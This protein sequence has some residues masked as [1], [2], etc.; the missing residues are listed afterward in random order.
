MQ[1]QDVGIRKGVFTRRYQTTQ[2]Y[3]KHTEFTPE[4][5]REFIND[6]LLQNYLFIQDAYVLGMN[7]EPS[8]QRKIYDYKVNSLANSHPVKYD[9][10]PITRE[11]LQV[12][13]NKKSLKYNV[14]FILTDT[15]A[16]A[17]SVS[18]HILKGGKIDPPMQ[19]REMMFPRTIQSE[20]LVYGESMVPP[21]IMEKLITMK[22]G[23]IS[24]PIYNMGMWT[25][26]ELNRKSKNH[27]L[28]EF[29]AIVDDLA[30]EAQGIQNYY[31]QLELLSDL[32]EKYEIILDEELYPTL[33]S[34]YVS[35]DGRGFINRE[36]LHPSD[37]AKPIIKSNEQNIV[38]A[39]FISN[40]NQ[41]IQH[42]NPPYIDKKDIAHFADEIINQY[43]LYLDVLAKD[44]K[45]S[46][47]LVD[48]IENKEHRILL[49]EYLN[50][51]IA[52]KIIITDKDAREYFEQ[53]RS[54][55]QA[56]FDNVKNSIK[57]VMKKERMVERRED[58]T[59]R[60]LKRSKIRYNDILL[61]EIADQLTEAKSHP[62]LTNDE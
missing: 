9:A 6:V 62:V 45:F 48:Q 21:V 42:S 23:G 7:K 60:L 54:E 28:K 58:I 52:D 50:K 43:L 8:V 59:N 18:E 44:L 25:I 10:A 11:Q 30:I 40:F 26:I 15:H 38:L 13:Y 31:A 34:A 33:I 61:Q 51:E 39:D 57:R 29:D 32:K 4:I 2:D 27:K 36:K 46:E 41:S 49:N 12:Y 16:M 1:L 37:L 5:L 24:K 20:E 19:G 14:G 3:G 47:L 35:K 53:H 56:E 22:N 17:K 55:W